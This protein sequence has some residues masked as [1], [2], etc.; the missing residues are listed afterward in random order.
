VRALALAEADLDPR[1]GAAIVRRAKGGKRREIELDR[2]AWEQLEPWLTIR[3]IS[4]RSSERRLY[5]EASEL[6]SG[7]R[8]HLP[9]APAN[10]LTI[11]RSSSIGCDVRSC[12][13]HDTRAAA[14]TGLKRA[15]NPVSVLANFASAGRL[16][17]AE[18]QTAELE[19]Y[20]SPLGWNRCSHASR[21]CSRD[22]H[23][24][25]S[26][27]PSLVL[28]ALSPQVERMFAGKT[29]LSFFRRFTR[30]KPVDCHQD[31]TGILTGC[32]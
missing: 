29:A 1:R 8:P 6:C 17:Q 9:T 14:K 13:G 12:S 16:R 20:R 21:D 30:N 10:V 7:G 19:C 23:R 32:H 22:G 28:L 2:W 31:V 4:S 11:G 27:T 15:W 5:Q 24:R 3:R 25:P 26:P 18:R